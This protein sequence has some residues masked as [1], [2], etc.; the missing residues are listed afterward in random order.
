M[1]ACSPAVK[2]FCVFL[3]DVAV[4]DDR[5]EAGHSDLA[6]VGVACEDEVRSGG[7]EGVE[8]A[9]V[10]GVRDCDAK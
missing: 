7:G 9:C 1:I 3:V 2:S 5:P 4:R 10:G 6:S 8:D